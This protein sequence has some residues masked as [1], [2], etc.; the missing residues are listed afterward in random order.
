MTNMWPC[1]QSQLPLAYMKNILQENVF[2]PDGIWLG[3]EYR[4]NL[5]LLKA[6]KI[7]LVIFAGLFPPGLLYAG[8]AG[9]WYMGTDAGV[10][11]QQTTFT[12]F[13]TSPAYPFLPVGETKFRPGERIDLKVGYNVKSWWATELEAGYI[14]NGISSIGSEPVSGVG[15]TQFPI[16]ANVIFSRLVSRGWSVYAGAGLGGIVSQ[17]NCGIK[18]PIRGFPYPP[19]FGLGATDTETDCVFGYQAIA[20]IK[21]VLS[22]NWDFSVGYQFLA[23][24]AG[25]DWKVN[26]WNFPGNNTITMDSTMSH[27]IVAAL[28]FTF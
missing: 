25:H 10:N 18:G 22:G 12:A 8:D 14:Y 1:R 2:R 3:M 5:N 26:N 20:G 21:Y 19:T 6:T 13:P 23:T 17:W 15:F 27:S 4:Q 7:L 16:M 9:T 24:T 11:L 28:T